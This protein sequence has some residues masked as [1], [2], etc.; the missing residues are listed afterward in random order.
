MSNS[1]LDFDDLST[2]A[3][4]AVRLAQAG[5]LDSSLGFL[6]NRLRADGYGM[7]GANLGFGIE[8]YKRSVPQCFAES[9]P[10]EQQT[11]KLLDAM[12]DGRADL[13]AGL[14]AKFAERAATKAAM[15]KA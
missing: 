8:Q 5:A 1:K 3:A 7:A 12:P 10:D 6:V 13:M 11:R 15:A 2:E 9:K 14:A 4:I